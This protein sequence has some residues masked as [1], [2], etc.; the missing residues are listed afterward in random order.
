[1]RRLFIFILHDTWGGGGSPHTPP[2]GRPRSVCFSAENHKTRAGCHLRP[3]HLTHEAHSCPPGRILQAN[4]SNTPLRGR[5]FSDSVGSHPQAERVN[6]FREMRRNTAPTMCA[7]SL[8]RGPD[9]WISL[10]SPTSAEGF[11]CT[12]AQLPVPEH[13]VPLLPGPPPL[14]TATPASPPGPSHHAPSSTIKQ[15]RHQVPKLRKHRD[16]KNR[17]AKDRCR[18]L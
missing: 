6:T 13:P 10:P 5:V 18:L 17:N 4:S 9:L 14:V 12:S 3:H 8:C 7:E 1:M 2:P 11:P 15:S 16:D